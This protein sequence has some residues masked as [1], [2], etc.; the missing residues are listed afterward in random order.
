MGTPTWSSATSLTASTAATVR[1]ATS[2]T[3]TATRTRETTMTRTADLL[4][5]TLQTSVLGGMMAGP[6]TCSTA[7]STGTAARRREPTSC[8]P[9]AWSSRPARCSATGRTGWTVGAGRLVTTAT[10]TVNRLKYLQCLSL[11]LPF[12]DTFFIQIVKLD[13]IGN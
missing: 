1:S 12:E 8:A 11:S 13:G 7:P 5:T 3:R 4:T 10:K 2:A 9:P 6:P